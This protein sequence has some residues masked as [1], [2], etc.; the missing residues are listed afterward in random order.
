MPRSILASACSLAA[1]IAV[2]APAR[3]LRSRIASRPRWR[4]GWWRMRSPPETTSELKFADFPLEGRGF[5]PS[6]PRGRERTSGAL[7]GAVAGGIAEVK[8]AIEHLPQ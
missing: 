4:T 5:E 1:A 8:K 2:A 3:V 7:N 6:V